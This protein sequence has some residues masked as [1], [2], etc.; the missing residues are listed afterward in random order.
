M[1]RLHRW[2][3][4]YR[5]G[6]PCRLGEGKTGDVFGDSIKNHSVLF[7]HMHHQLLFIDRERRRR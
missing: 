2:V 1:V 4:S 6:I 7:A 5:M 3:L